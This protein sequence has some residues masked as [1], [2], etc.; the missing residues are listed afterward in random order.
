[1]HRSFAHSFLD[2]GLEEK[3]L[4]SLRAS[5]HTMK[6]CTLPWIYIYKHGRVHKHTQINNFP[7]GLQKLT[8]L[9]YVSA[10]LSKAKQCK[11]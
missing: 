5:L 10:I 9:G 11:D 8:F 7:S 4:N 2:G 3:G 6:V 1:M